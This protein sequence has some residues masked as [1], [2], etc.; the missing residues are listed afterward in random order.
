MRWIG[1]LMVVG[2]FVFGCSKKEKKKPAFHIEVVDE[3]GNEGLYSGVDVG[4]DG[5]V[6]ICY[7]EESA[8]VPPTVKLKFARRDPQTNTW[9]ITLVDTSGTAGYYCRIAVDAQNRPHI[10]YYDHANGDLKYAHYDGS[11]WKTEVV[12]SA[13]DVGAFCDIDTDAQ[14]RPHISYLDKTNGVLKH[15]YFDGASWQ[16]ESLGSYGTIEGQTNIHIDD[17][18]T[19]HIVYWYAPDELRRTWFDGASWQTETIHSGSNV[20]EYNWLTSRNGILHVVFSDASGGGGTQ[21]GHAVYYQGAWNPH[22]DDPVEGSGEGC[23]IAVRSDGSPHMVYY[24]T[25]YMQLRYYCHAGGSPRWQAVDG[26]SNVGRNPAVAVGPDDTLHITYY[27][28]G[29]GRLKYASRR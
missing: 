15:A 12:D 22:I 2:V 19:I 28:A 11:S 10:C 21:L 6:Q 27:D 13:G 24:N 14:N 25:T 16:T 7:C 9:Q 18:G 4:S 5:V 20:G 26:D 29:R 8:G 3:S 17:A 1:V 23:A